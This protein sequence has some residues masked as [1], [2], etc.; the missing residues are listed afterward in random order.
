MD[1][2]V[3]PHSRPWITDSDIEAVNSVL[4][5][6]QISQGPKVSAFET[7]LAST[8]GKNFAVA[9][10]SGTSALH[11]ALLALEVKEGDEIIIPSFV[12]TAVLNAVNYTRAI[13]RI[14]DI[15]P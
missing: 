8:I 2:P 15:D 11:L 6:G 14:V 9:T 7:K 13:P 1:Y 12:C 4:K 3:I 5:S 10:S